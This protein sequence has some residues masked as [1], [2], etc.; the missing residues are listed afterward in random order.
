MHIVAAAAARLL[1]TS[2]FNYFNQK[3]IDGTAFV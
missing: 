1:L 3:V 2:L